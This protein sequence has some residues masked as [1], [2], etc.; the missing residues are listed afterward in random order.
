MVEKYFMSKLVFSLFHLTEVSAIKVMQ[1]LTKC[2]SDFGDLGIKIVV[3]SFAT[4]FSVHAMNTLQ[5]TA[6]KTTV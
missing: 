4:S 6:G 5:V 3:F 2:T 1:Q